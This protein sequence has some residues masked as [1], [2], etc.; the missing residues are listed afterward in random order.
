MCLPVAKA[1][2]AEVVLAVVALHVVATA[3]LLNAALAL[4]AVLDVLVARRPVLEAAVDSLRTL[5]APVP[6]L[7]AGK[8]D[9]KAAL[10]GDLA[11]AALLYIVRAVRPRTPLHQRVQIHVD[12]LLEP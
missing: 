8:A 4:G 12:V 5:E 10:A 1:H 11:R 6:L 2:P 9:L 7:P 3:V